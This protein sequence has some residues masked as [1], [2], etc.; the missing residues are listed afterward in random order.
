[1]REHWPPRRPEEADSS[2]ASPPLVFVGGSGRSG[3]HVVAAL[4]GHHSRYAGVAIEAR[5]HANPRGIPD[6]LAGEV[7]EDEFVRK[8]RRFWWH[9]VAAGEPF[10][11]ILPRLPLGRSLRGLHK[12]MPRR[13]FD[14]AIERFDRRWRRDRETACRRLFLELLWP[15]ADQAGKPGLVEMTTATV[16]QAPTLSRLFPEARFV[17]AVRDGRDAGS[18]KVA[19]RQKREHPRDVFQGLAWWRER[20]EQNEQGIAATPHGRIHHLPLDQ[21]AAGSDGA[22]E[23]AYE[24][25]LAFLGV[26]DE[27]PMRGYFESEIN[28][29]N[30]N[31]GRA[32]AGLSPADRR[33][34]DR[35]YEEILDEIEARG[36]ASA[37]LL[38][39]AYERLG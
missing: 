15:I 6:L 34:L 12:V 30:A 24:S 33:E 14:R 17:H 10:P 21:L 28:A 27:G 38:R 16:H 26:E 35:R 37:P 4:L 5:F 18:S 13:R 25:L 9:R 29:A 11:A 20:L 23:A 22:R 31:R 7:A 19:K 8:L 2:P 36:F 3:T 39:E 32:R 1:M